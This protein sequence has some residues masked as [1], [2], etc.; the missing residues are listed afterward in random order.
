MASALPKAVGC[1]NRHCIPASETLGWA[2]RGLDAWVRLLGSGRRTAAPGGYGR[3]REPQS[4][5]PPSIIRVLVRPGSAWGR[6]PVA[7]CTKLEGAEGTREPGHS[8]G[9]PQT[10]WT[11][12]LR[13]GGIRSPWGCQ[14]W[15]GPLGRAPQR[16][17]SPQLV[18]GP[19][20]WLCFYVRLAGGPAR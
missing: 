2:L 6:D 13:A 15:T 19:I 8:L 11:G 20:S 18:L 12:S 3:G 17:W 1:V 14:R 10:P 16:T 9:R 7:F 4:S 5:D